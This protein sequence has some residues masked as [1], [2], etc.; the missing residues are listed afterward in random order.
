MSKFVISGGNKLFG[1]VTIQSAKN[2]LLPLISACILV[3]GKVT[4][5]NCNKLEYITSFN[6]N[7][8]SVA[9]NL[10]INTDFCTLFIP[11]EAFT[12]YGKHHY[13][14]KFINIET[15]DPN[16]Y[17]KISIKT[18][19]SS[20]NDINHYYYINDSIKIAPPS[21][22]GY[23]F[24]QWSDGNTENP[25]TI[26]VTQDS[27]FT[28][29][30]EINTYTVILSAENGAV[31]GAGTYN[32]GEEATIAVIPNEG[33]TFD[34]WSDGNTDNPRKIIV[35]ED[36]NL[37]AILKSNSPSTNL[38]SNFNTEI[39][40]YTTNG[41]LHIEGATSDYH[42]LDAAGR[43][44]YS[45]NATTLQLPRGIYLI[46]MGGETQKIVL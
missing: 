25:R 30:F 2:S 33:Y 28:A 41:T 31:T 37:I 35:T 22:D 18:N 38:D 3:E 12:N 24:T 46:T 36:V 21:I 42:I 40:I 9:N 10:G 20:D 27:T 19:L 4:F 26:V 6:T 44:I 23:H 14:S 8:P 11:K 43:L 7:P 1:E 34:K 17:K 5:L 16:Y 45:G 39:R 13:W 15:L 29:E 32:H